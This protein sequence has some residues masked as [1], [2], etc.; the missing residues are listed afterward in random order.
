[1]NK[2]RAL[3]K[4]AGLTQVE[5]AKICGMSR[6]AYQYREEDAKYKESAKDVLTLLK[7]KGF[8]GELPSILP[9]RFIKIEC[10]EIFARYPEVKCAYL[11][12]SYARGEATYKSDVDIM[13]VAPDLKGFAFAKLHHDL[14]VAFNKDVDLIYHTTLLNSERMLRD[15]LMQGEKIYTIKK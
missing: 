3:R 9:L 2:L 10:S 8:N 14:R 13:V 4:K 1:M 15:I 7:E 11:F 5:A 12:G 6:R